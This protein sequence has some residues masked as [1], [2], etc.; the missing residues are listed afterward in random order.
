MRK[1]TSRDVKKIKVGK[2]KIKELVVSHRIISHLFSG[3]QLLLNSVDHT[4]KKTS[5]QEE[6]LLQRVPGEEG[7]NEGG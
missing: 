6:G 3:K 1:L 7:G 4:H 5:V 2:R